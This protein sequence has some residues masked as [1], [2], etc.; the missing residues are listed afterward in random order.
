MIISFRIIYLIIYHN[1]HMV[2]KTY[3]LILTGWGSGGHILP[4]IALLQTLDQTRS[5]RQHVNYVYWLWE[6]NGLE[7]KFFLQ[8]KDTFHHI[9]LQFLSISAGKFR[10]ETIWRSRLKNIRDICIFPYGVIQSLRYIFTKNIDIVFCKWWYVSLPV[11]IAAWI[12]HKKI[13]VHDSDTTPGLT[14]RIASRFALQNFSWFPDTLPK[15]I[16]VGQLLSSDLLLKVFPISSDNTIIQVLVAWWSLGAQKL[17]NAVLLTLPLLWSKISHFHFTFI[18]G[19]H[20]IDKKLIIWFEKNITITDLIIDQSQMGQYYA[21]SDVGIVR[22]GT[23]TLAECKLFDLPLIIVPLPVT[24]DQAKNA[25]Y[26]VHYYHDSVLSQND[27][28]F[29]Q[30]LCQLLQKTQKKHHNSSYP[31]LKQKIESPKQI[32]LDKMLSL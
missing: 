19:N 28:Q 15:T 4:L 12:L 10:R 31:T 11:V 7:Y 25:D 17:Y 2:Q 9:K 1:R 30:L 16:P 20:I 27:L 23:T 5:Y 13:Y 21:Q 18:N 26:Y 29:T 3:N 6:K 8:Y 14:T 22:W 32:I 24:H